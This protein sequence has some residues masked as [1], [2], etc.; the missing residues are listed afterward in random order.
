MTRKE[1]NIPGRDTITPGCDFKNK[2]NKKNKKKICN[3]FAQS[4][5]TLFQKANASLL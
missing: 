5:M 3:A 1:H 2:E 4:S